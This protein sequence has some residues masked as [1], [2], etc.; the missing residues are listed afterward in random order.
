VTA[1]CQG[2]WKGKIK[3]RDFTIL[4]QING[5]PC[6]VNRAEYFFAGNKA[7]SEPPAIVTINY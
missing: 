6:L 2:L 3:G 1:V 4:I 7:I 5:C